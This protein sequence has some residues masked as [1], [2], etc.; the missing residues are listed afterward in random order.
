MAPTATMRIDLS[1]SLEQILARMSACKRRAIRHSQRAGVE[2][3]MGSRHDLDVFHS[4]YQ[5]TARRQGFKAL[6]LAY[7]RHH[8]EALDPRGGCA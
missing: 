2:V 4:L 5:A 3:R 1:Q 8:W 6:S 7:L